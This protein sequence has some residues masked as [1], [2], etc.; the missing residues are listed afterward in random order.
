MK[1]YDQSTSRLLQV[2]RKATAD[3]WDQ[4]WTA[5]EVGT[6]NPW[7]VAPFLDLTRRYLASGSLVLEGGC[8]AGGKV[9][10]LQSA[11]FRTIGIDYANETVARLNRT[12][13]QLDIREGNV[14]SLD[15]ADGHFDGY[16][17]F[18]V[19]EHFWGG[20][21]PILDEARR[22]LRDQGYFFMTVPCMSPLRKLK[23]A[24]G[25]YP[26]WAGGEQEPEGFYQFMLPLEAVHAA[27]ENAGFQVV[28]SSVIQAASGAKQEFAA[29]WKLAEILAR[30]SGARNALYS[31]WA[32]NMLGG[33]IGHIA[34]IAARLDKS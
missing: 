21:Q 32:E 13:P 5:D 11:G 28:E 29:L 8:G 9:A 33:A 4:K 24:M 30:L 10:A 18:G 12:C 19:I 23:A 20:Y 14:F 31:S 25:L 26:R 15:F 1:Y 17:S 27:L 16:W 7:L 3:F 22:I 34:L 2:K 6:F